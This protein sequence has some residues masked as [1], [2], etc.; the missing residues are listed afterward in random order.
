MFFSFTFAALSFIH[1]ENNHYAYMLENFD[2]DWIYT[3]AS[4][5]F[6]NYTNL[7][8]GE[9]IFKVKGS[10]NDGV[11]NPKEASIKITITPP[12]GKHGG[13]QF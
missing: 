3:D 6:A 8:P 1:P 2:K 13:S 12:F 11:W 4:K 5:R 9:Y 10:N 7:D